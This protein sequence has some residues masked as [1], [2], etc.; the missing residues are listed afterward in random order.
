VRS[1]LVRYGLAVTS[2]VLV[3]FL[4]P[5]GFLARSLTQERALSAGRQDAQQVSLFTDD[6]VRLQ[7]ALVAVNAGNR[8]TTVFTTTGT[9]VGAPA[10]DTPS[11]ALAR[12]G[13][14]FTADTAGGVEVLVPVAGAD[15]VTV[16]RTFVPDSEL[17]A[18]VYRA[19]AV[20]AA[21]GVG[22]LAFT[23]LAGY[24]IASGLSR[25]VSD[26][27]SVASRLGAGDLR[28][29]VEPSG[30]GEVVSVGNVLNG[31]GAQVEDLLADEREL[32][33][34]L[35]HRLRTPITALRLDTE[36]LTD[37]LERERL[38]G[39]V[40]DLVAVVDTV[41]EA[42]RSHQRRAPVRCDAAQVVRDR[43]KFW[44]VLAASQDRPFTATV[45]DSP[46]LVAT[47]AAELGAGLDVVV[48]N[49]FKHTDAG[50]ALALSV[51]T[52][53]DVVRVT[54]ADAGPGLPDSELAGRGKSGAGSTG[55][56]LDV[57]RRTAEQ[58]SG[59][60]ELGTG[61]DGRGMSVT[62]RLPKALA[63]L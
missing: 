6:P 42:A 45:V 61:L 22:L 60:L 17:M 28:A 43:A 15:G 51:S 62:F 53:G 9:I 34:D 2:I 23:A 16:V 4:L 12:S 58:A 57:A 59:T 41:I 56:G 11:V 36:L 14:A 1:L 44:S 63:E 3:A 54:V 40:E 18:G 25:S 21:V 20:L 30:P 55:I 19:W 10:E 38:G 32:I 52:D 5:L 35:S 31:L 50:T 13:Q 7:A 8:R 37:P 46:A 48:D 49:I 27:A 26:L 29:R 47:G 39:H 33:A 24:R